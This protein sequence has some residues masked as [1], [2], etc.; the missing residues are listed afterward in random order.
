MLMDVYIWL[1]NFC[2]IV[3]DQNLILCCFFNYLCGVV[4]NGQ[5]DQGLLFICYQCDLYQGFIVVQNCLNGELFE[6]Y[7][8]FVGGGY[9]FVLFGVVGDENG[10][11][12]GDYF[13]CGLID[14]VRWV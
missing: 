4:K 7:I 13:V 5:L 2:D 3:S 14:V 12:G 8:K 11:Q 9:F 6:E 1:V 10:Q